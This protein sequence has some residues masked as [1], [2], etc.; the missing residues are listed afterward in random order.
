MEGIRK[1]RLLVLGIS[2]AVSGCSRSSDE[3]HDLKVAFYPLDL[4][5]TCD[6]STPSPLR[7]GYP[8]HDVENAVGTACIERNSGV[9]AVTISKIDIHRDNAF[10]DPVYEIHFQIDQKDW[11]RVDAVM[12]KATQSHR[13]LAEIVH[14]A[15]V[16][17]ASVITPPQAGVIEIGGYDS[18]EEAEVMASR[19]EVPRARES[20]A[21]GGTIN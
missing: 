10:R 1:A 20:G 2:L 3:T 13:F 6:Q 21:K 17:R 14:G 11:E 8:V 19:F 7:S 18:V 5:L 15:V 12:R 9:N 16:A 4:A